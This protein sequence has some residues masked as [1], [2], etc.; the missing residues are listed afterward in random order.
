MQKAG[1]DNIGYFA[2]KP[3]HLLRMAMNLQI[4]RGEHEITEVALEEASDIF[5]W[6]EDNT[7]AVIKMLLSTEHGALATTII[8]L[9]KK[10]GGHAPKRDVLRTLTK[11]FPPRLVM[12]SIQTLFT[13][14]Q[15]GRY[16][17]GQRAGDVFFLKDWS[18][19]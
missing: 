19:D 15:L 11:S 4:S 16:D 14:E 8:Q 5:T 13:T 12:E 1:E 3:D 7:P 18:D 10:S 9:L 6:L 2:R 17:G